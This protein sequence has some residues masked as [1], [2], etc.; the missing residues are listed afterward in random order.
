MRAGREEEITTLAPKARQASA[1][2][3]PMPEL[4]PMMRTRWPASLEV[5]LV[6]SD[7]FAVVLD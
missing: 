5:Y 7:I 2:E 1:T 6:E 3:K 4:P